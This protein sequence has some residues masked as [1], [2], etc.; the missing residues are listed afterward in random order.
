MKKKPK[1]KKAGI[2]LRG[3][4]GDTLLRAWSESCRRISEDDSMTVAATDAGFVIPTGQKTGEREGFQVFVE[5]RRFSEKL[6]REEPISGGLLKRR[7]DDG[8]PGAPKNRCASEVP[9]NGPGEPATGLEGKPTVDLLADAVLELSERSLA[10]EGKLTALERL[11]RSLMAP[12][13]AAPSNHQPAN[14]PQPP[15]GFRWVTPE[16]VLRELKLIP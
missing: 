13:H 6:L 7:S 14:V 10:I 11:M 16:E 4:T 15:P 5:M 1:T 2:H 9:I 3:A 8:G 12:M